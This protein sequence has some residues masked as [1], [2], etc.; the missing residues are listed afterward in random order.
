[1]GNNK[2]NKKKKV[3][4]KEDLSYAEL[5]KKYRFYQEQFIFTSNELLKTDNPNLIECDKQ[6]LQ[7]CLEII[8]EVKDKLTNIDNMN[9][10]GI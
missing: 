10:G 3:W 1:M 8:K 5:I 6:I 9:A 7:A 4:L 2:K